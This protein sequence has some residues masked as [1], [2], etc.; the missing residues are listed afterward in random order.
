M[1]GLLVMVALA[2][3]LIAIARVRDS[4]LSRRR[5]LVVTDPTLGVLRYDP[6]VAAWR[7]PKAPI[8]FLIGG[9]LEPDL[10]LRAH[11]SEVQRT[12]DAFLLGIRD[13]LEREASKNEQWVSDIRGLKLEEVCFFWPE[14]PDD[15]ML[16]FAA[17][18]PD[19]RVWRC[20]YVNRTPRALGFDS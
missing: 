20:D 17:A 11:A 7:S 1:K 13:Y 15:G 8:Q 12:A 2:L 19:T 4:I 10:R 9:T 6:E 5:V 18:P 14:R 3:V 16:Y